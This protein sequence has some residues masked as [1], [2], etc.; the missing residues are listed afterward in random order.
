MKTNIS[1]PFKKHRFR[2]IFAKSISFTILIIYSLI[3]MVPFLWSLLSSLKNNNEILTT[4]FSI[5]LNP[6][7]KN[8]P[9]AWG[10]AKMGIYF[11]NTIF[12]VV[13]ATIVVVVISALAAYI[14]ARVLK[15]QLL[16][17][18]FTLGIMVPVHTILLPIFLIVQKLGISNTRLGI[19]LAFISTQL[20]MSIFIM[21]GF[22]KS[23]PTEIEEASLIDGC[24][25]TSAFFRIIFPLSKAGIATIATLCFLN[26]WNDY[27]MP[28]ILITDSNLKVLT[29]GI[30]DLKGL[31]SQDYGL[32]C[33]GIVIATVPVIIMYMQL[34]ENFVAGLTTGAV[35]G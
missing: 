2:E 22:M 26:C 3:S 19:I 13:V 4:P 29:L 21:T 32:I 18:Y 17:T 35:K 23:F 6:V 12:Y 11:V 27:L 10:K 5:P 15:S 8:F 24:N 16:L 14:L 20:A 1:K 25:K 33:T 9:L 31:Y 28:L 34:Q 30:Q 7:F